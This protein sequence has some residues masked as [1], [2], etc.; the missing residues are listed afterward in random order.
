MLVGCL[1]YFFYRKVN[2][3]TVVVCLDLYKMFVFPVSLWGL[4]VCCCFFTVWDYTYD[5]VP[6]QIY[7]SISA[8]LLVSASFGVVLAL[9]AF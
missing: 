7:K 3:N 6:V 5:L 1:V 2:W 9:G 8:Q 4:F